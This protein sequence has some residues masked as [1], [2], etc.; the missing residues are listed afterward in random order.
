MILLERAEELRR[1]TRALHRV[2]A[3]RGDR[4]VITGELGCGKSALLGAVR[5][6][7]GET[8]V[9][10]ATCS[11]LE[12]DF[13]FGV[14]RQLLD[15]ALAKA[16]ER[17]R[18]R[19]FAGPAGLA[20]PV[21]CDDAPAEPAVAV[22]DAAISGLIALTRALSADEP[23]VLLI[24][25]LHWADD[26]S[27]RWLGRLARALD[28]HP[29]LLV[30]ATGDGEHRPFPCTEIRPEPLSPQAI[31][32]LVA[33]RTGTTPDA[34][35][36]AACHDVTGGNPLF[37]DAVLSHVTS[38]SP[39]QV[40][41]V[42]H[43]RP[44]RLTERLV[45][46][47]ATLPKHAQDLAKATAVLA[48]DDDLAGQLAGLTE[49]QA[50]AAHRI[51]EQAGFTTG[52][53]AVRDAIEE[54]MPVGEREEWQ[55]RAVKLL[56]DNGRPAEL[57]AARLLT[58]TTT[59]GGW[60]IGTLREAAATAL[61]RGAP[62]V[63]ARYLRRA[64]RDV[65][66]D[67][68]DRARLLVDLAV[69]E[70]FFD[71]AA[72]VRHITHA[73]PL[74]RD[75][76]E[77]AAA[78]VRIAP[79]A[80]GQAPRPV[81]DLIDE[82]AGLNQDEELGYRLEARQRYAWHA[83]PSLLTDPVPRLRQ[84]EGGT[85]GERE[86]R[87]VL[88]DAA[89]FTARLPAPEIAAIASTAL[90][91]ETPHPRHVH[92][93][94]P[95]LIRALAAADAAHEAVPWLDQALS[96]ATTTVDQALIRAQQSF[97]LLHLGQP[98]EAHRA[99]EHALDLAVLDWRGDTTTA[100]IGLTAVAM[101]LRDPELIGKIL[102]SR[103]DRDEP[104]GCDAV[105]RMLHAAA[106]AL[107]GEHAQALQGLLDCGRVLDGV[108][109]RNPVLL[110]WSVATARLHAQLGDLAAAREAA[111]R[112]WDRAVEWGAPIGI[113]RAL[114]V[115]GRYTPD[116]EGLAMLHEA[117]EILHAN[118]F[119]RA[120]ALLQLG[121]RERADGDPQA[122]HHLHEAHR[123]ALQSGAGRLAT[124]IA[125]ELDGN[126]PGIAVALTRTE[127]KVA[128]LVVQGLTNAEIAEELSVTSR[129]IEK[130]LTNSFRKLGIRRRTELPA[131]LARAYPPSV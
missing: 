87:A 114:R 57:V 48:G 111:A 119:E 27:L 9:L 30:A 29:L 62:E 96:R 99:A 53:P 39:D 65:P 85:P 20:L 130:H 8:R 79:T 6:R 110:P 76:R 103:P 3:G 43:L 44:A 92:T 128:G 121:A 101:E 89:V 115:L 34:G 83:D 109:W 117:V 11:A 104:A 125:K 51:L 24:D 75:V 77:R 52:R 124:R 7:A 50:R 112:A 59:P 54:S 67:S 93:A 84:I 19:W 71:P 49:Q 126:S 4:I 58:V 35:F 22:E 123:L 97:V 18:E 78:L 21:F 64:L 91:Q 63:A 74:F 82:V 2:R 15:P 131:A 37:L 100:A 26:P 86:L 61:R 42:R 23:T 28:G 17:T 95:L 122:Q 106:K 5:D 66:G 108:G 33:H 56:H 113:G 102:S 12:R 129:A 41:H 127:F 105:Y 81:R 38:P 73:V 72:S 68:E 1:L 90:N 13:A 25:D 32:E 16:C 116:R 46:G 31:A 36:V 69:A 94:V 60:A 98:G 55:A 118:P 45:R 10:T 40:P 70:R 88:L 47:L 80:L 120:K 14:A 107:A